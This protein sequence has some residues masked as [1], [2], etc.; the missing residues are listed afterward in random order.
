MTPYLPW[1]IFWHFFTQIFS[2]NTVRV[3]FLWWYSELDIRARA[4]EWHVLTW[5]LKCRL[6][7]RNKKT[8]WLYSWKKKLISVNPNVQG[9]PDPPRTW[10]TGLLIVITS[11]SV[12][13]S[14]WQCL[15]L[16]SVRSVLHRDR[17]SVSFTFFW[18]ARSHITVL[19]TRYTSI[20]AK[21]CHDYHD[22]NLT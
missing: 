21:C 11:H 1:L 7:W 2:L 18:N 6:Y 16:L 22:L 12:C 4:I 13:L 15:K 8:L 19:W 20:L 5:T 17:Q 9:H 14:V 3:M 10:Y